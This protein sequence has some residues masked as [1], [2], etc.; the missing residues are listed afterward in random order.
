MTTIKYDV[1]DRVR[2]QTKDFGNDVEGKIQAIQ[3]TPE[4]G[5]KYSLKLYYPNGVTLQGEDVS[6]QEM[7]GSVWVQES[8]IRGKASMS[9]DQAHE[10]EQLIF[11]EPY[12]ERNYLGGIRSF[13]NLNPKVAYTLVEKGFLD[14]D[15]QQ[16]NSPT[17]G[18]F[19]DF[20]ESGDGVWTLHGYV[21]SRDRF[22]TRVSIEGIDGIGPFSVDTIVAFSQLCHDADEFHIDTDSAHC[23][24]D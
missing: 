11:H 19:L 6:G 1:G 18:Q 17:V 20:F 23:W 14:F 22:D 21:V 16:N 7:I 9:L 8:A 12:N 15:E 3:I 24:Y 4:K 2:I 5:P 13:K 10:R